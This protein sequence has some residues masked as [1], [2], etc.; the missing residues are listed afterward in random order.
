M[1]QHR[2]RGGSRQPQGHIQM[3]VNLIHFGMNPQKADDPPRICHEAFS[4]PAR[5]DRQ[6]GI[7][8]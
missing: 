7:E 6:P 4:N 1:E 2:L 8:T 5:T 3:V